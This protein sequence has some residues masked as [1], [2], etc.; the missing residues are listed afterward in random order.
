LSYRIYLIAACLCMIVATGSGQE[1]GEVGIGF[2][3][4]DPTGFSWKVR[5]RGGNA[6]DGVVGFSPFDRFRLHADY[7]WDSRPFN[8]KNL[9]L[10][11]G[12]GIAFGFGRTEYVVISNRNGL[13]LRNEELGFA[14]RGLFGISYLIRR[15]PVEVYFELA[16]LI[17]FTPGTGSGLDV[18]FGARLYP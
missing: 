4:G 11:Y 2:V 14:I 13:L 1:R 3:V 6:I 12:P 10:Y 8:E 5:L 17:I 9:S 7:L 16:P 15:S 18:G